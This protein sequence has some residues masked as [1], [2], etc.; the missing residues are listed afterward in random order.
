MY[1]RLKAE[2][3]HIMK[4]EEFQLPHYRAGLIDFRRGDDDMY[5]LIWQ[6]EEVYKRKT[7]PSLCDFCKERPRSTWLSGS[8]GA[9]V[10]RMLDIDSCHIGLCGRCAFLVLYTQD[11]VSS[12]QLCSC[13]RCKPV[14]Y[15]LVNGPSA[16]Q[17]RLPDG[18]MSSRLCKKCHLSG[19]HG[20]E[21]RAALKAIPR[22]ARLHRSL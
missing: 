22:D 3:R 18:N 4:L 9:N 2:K 6:R 20:E 8:D 13:K 21:I 12:A 1:K 10:G 5:G 17:V 11:N 16:Y 14:C 7:P 19:A 15:S